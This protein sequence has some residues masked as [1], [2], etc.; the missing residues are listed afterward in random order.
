MFANG[1]L[2]SDLRKHGLLNS[3]PGGAMLGIFYTVTGTVQRF[4]SLETKI[5]IYH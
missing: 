4:D 5:F 2:T 1:L 3:S